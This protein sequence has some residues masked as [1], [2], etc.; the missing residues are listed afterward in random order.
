MPDMKGGKKFSGA[1]GGK[2]DNP[3]SKS[4]KDMD[5]KMNRKIER[6]KK[7]AMKMSKKMGKKKM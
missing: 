7:S 6:S 4:M 5:P 2:Q 3:F 1:Y